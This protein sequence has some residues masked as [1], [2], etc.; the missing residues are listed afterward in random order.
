MNN[1]AIT[2]N[3]EQTLITGMCDITVKEKKTSV[4][5]ETENIL[6]ISWF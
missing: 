4:E 6:L 3:F 5:L 1:T 2:D